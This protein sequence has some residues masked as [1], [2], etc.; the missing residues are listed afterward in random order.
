MGL[1]GTHTG[2]GGGNPWRAGK[3][4]SEQMMCE[5]TFE[6]C[7][8]MVISVLVVVSLMSAFQV[9]LPSSQ[10]DKHVW[11]SGGKTGL[12]IPICCSI[13]IVVYSSVLY[14]EF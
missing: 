4:V 3:D 1:S 11:S 6:G 13:W 10:S 12:E 7:Q 8:E 9:G 14:T 5:P 2:P